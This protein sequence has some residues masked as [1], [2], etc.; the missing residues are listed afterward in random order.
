MLPLIDTHI[1]NAS[2]KDYKLYAIDLS[3]VVM[4]CQYM[5]RD[6]HDSKGFTS[7]RG[8]IKK[9]LETLTVELVL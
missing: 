6:T 4:A 7:Y 8:L 5:G 1:K 9:K 3:S 2:T